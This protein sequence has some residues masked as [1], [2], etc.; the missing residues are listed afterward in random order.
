M[1]RF[2]HVGIVVENM[3]ESLNFYTNILGCRVHKQHRDE[4]L[5]FTLLEAGGQE[6]ELLKFAVDNK[7]RKEGVISHIAFVVEDME[8]EISRLKE[9]GVRLSTDQPRVVLGGM[10]IFFFTGPSGESIEFVQYSSAK[11]DTI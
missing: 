9:S 5:Q 2:S 6:I 3:E 8:K 1:Y 10:K 7:E 11:G 4:D